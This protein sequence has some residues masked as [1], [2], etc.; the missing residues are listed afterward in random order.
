MTLNNETM[1]LPSFDTLNEE[2]IDILKQIPDY[3]LDFNI[4]IFKGIRD[5]RLKIADDLKE[6]RLVLQDDKLKNGLELTSTS[7]LQDRLLQ[8]LI[9]ERHRRDI[10]L[11]NLFINSRDSSKNVKAIKLIQPFNYDIKSPIFKKLNSSAENYQES[12][13]KFAILQNLEYEFE[14]QLLNDDELIQ[15]FISDEILKFNELYLKD[16]DKPIEDLFEDIFNEGKFIRIVIP[17][18]AQGILM[19]VDIEKEL[20]V[21]S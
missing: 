3:P 14:E 6:F 15:E 17:L 12:F 9:I 4:F 1:V 20:S 19:G 18:A 21:E 5:I 10:E 8:I 16:K 7:Q 13:R 11:L 2:S